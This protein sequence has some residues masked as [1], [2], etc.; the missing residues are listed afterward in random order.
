MNYY[1][2][3]LLTNTGEIIAG[4]IKLPYI[5]I[6]SAITHLEK[7]GNTVIYVKKPGPIYLFLFKL[8]SIGSK[9]KLKRAAQA[10]LLS[11]I[12]LMIKSG[13]NLTNALEEASSGAE[14]PE[15]G[16][17][18]YEMISMIQSGAV[19]SEAA[20]SF[21]H[22][23]PPTIIHLIKIGEETG[24]LDQMLDNAANHLKNIEKIVSD[25]KQALMYPAF[26]F[27]AM[28]I[29]VFFWFY[30]V[31]PQILNL[32]KEMDVTLPA[33]TLFLLGLSDF[34][35]SNIFIIIALIIATPI[36]FVAARKNFQPF[37][38]VTDKL[39][40]KLP[41]AGTII[42][43][44]SLAY[45]SEYLSL[46]LNSGIDILNSLTI[47][48]QSVGNELYKNKI[49][50]IKEGILKGHGVTESFTETEI[51]PSFV[52]RM[53]GVGELSGTLT[54]QL[55]HIAEEYRNRLS[56]LVSS[57]GKALEPIVLLVAGALFIVIIA[58]LLL[59]IYDLISTI[60]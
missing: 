19:F 56:V 16:D 23:F 32:F 53:I 29:L 9:Q 49:L 47:L 50:D 6:L 25:T 52:T 7:D 59:P 28:L 8:L 20:I 22:I 1:K 54:E 18:I 4:M 30:Y 3:K 44:S 21:P 14:I 41:I 15:I 33:I 45:I 26:V 48:H 11:N 43:A 17:D 51:F 10:E 36:V 34:I 24:K 57:I 46:L 39:L 12:S 31:I 13:V 60:A 2:F 35:R 55:D 5:D 38:T 27:L 40:I 58:G 42:T 37:K